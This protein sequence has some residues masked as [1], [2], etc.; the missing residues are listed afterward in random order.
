MN[1]E[2]TLDVSHLEEIG[3]GTR[4]PIWW[5][6]VGMMA[7]ETTIFAILIAAYFYV[8]LGFSV[9]PP[10]NIAPPDLPLATVN[11]ILL[12]VSCIP[13]YLGGEAGMQGK[14]GKAALM[15]AL[16]AL[17]A[18][19]FLITRAMELN[20][21]NFK[22]STDIYGSFVWTLLGL[23]TMHTIADTVE[24]IVIIGI[25]LSGRVG[26]KQ[27]LGL[28]MDGLYWYWLTAIW[29]PLYLLIYVYPAITK[30]A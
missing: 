2:A 29:I 8:R 10:P 3:F 11:T 23:H 17:L 16:N 26:G 28:K 14:L 22:W 18:L 25:L 24:S 4:A 20:R 1:N 13:M 19:A 21:L 12:L 15:T 6:Q 27:Q 5:G 7:I 9:W 30:Y